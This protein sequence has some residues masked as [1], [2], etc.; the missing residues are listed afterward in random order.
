MSFDTRAIDLTFVLGTGPFGDGVGNTATLSAGDDPHNV[1]R[2]SAKIE[3][4]G[5]TSMTTLD[6]QV[7]G[8]TPSVMNKLST[9]GLVW[10]RL[11][12]NTVTVAAGTIDGTKSVVFNGTISDAWIDLETAP[13]ATFRVS[14]QVGGIESVKTAIPSSFTAGADVSTIMQTLASKMGLG[15]EP[16]G[17]SV[18]LS[19][20]Y[21]AGSYRDQAL[22][23]A[24]AAGVESVIDNGTLA[25]WPRG[26]SRQG[27]I[28][29]IS[30][31]TGMIGY[32]GYTSKGI[33]VR[34]VFN[35]A[36]LFGGNIKV[37]S[38]LGLTDGQDPNLSP[39]SGMWNVF[40][41]DYDLEAGASGGKWE[42]TI[43]AT[44]PGNPVVD[45]G[46]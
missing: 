25:I 36:V 6:M 5:G 12:N 17:T 15:F 31:D 23:A 32:P 41:I 3:K 13:E 22:R 34:T 24:D 40:G 29:L 38:S 27:Q 44:R 9:L 1:R 33:S 11:R 10:T 35:P 30:P 28:P 42:M 18:I 39:A 8:M 46:S 43:R 37:I 4:A 26:G 21:L 14:A 45:N 16:N 7:Y 20:Q 19:N 2:V